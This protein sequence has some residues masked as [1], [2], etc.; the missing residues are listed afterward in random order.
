MLCRFWKLSIKFR[1]FYRCFQIDSCREKLHK[2]EL[3]IRLKT[4]SKIVNFL[5]I[6]LIFAFYF[7]GAINPPVCRRTLPKQTKNIWKNPPTISWWSGDLRSDFSWRTAENGVRNQRP[8]SFLKRFLSH[9]MNLVNIPGLP[10]G[11]FPGDFSIAL[12]VAVATAVPF[13]V[14]Q[15]IDH[16]ANS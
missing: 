7:F 4:V 16:D 1:R 14:S 9:S 15:V 5:W 6:V 3:S 13:S 11:C 10:L 12:N 8:N 2:N